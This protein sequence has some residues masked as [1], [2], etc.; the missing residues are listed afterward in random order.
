[1][2]RLGLILNAVAYLGIAA[3]VL[4]MSW[5]WI[6]N[7]ELSQMQVLQRTW[8]MLVLMIVLA[9]PAVAYD[10]YRRWNSPG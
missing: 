3:Y 10:V 8:G 7:P 9:I 6:Q 4:Y 2:K 5:V 1:M